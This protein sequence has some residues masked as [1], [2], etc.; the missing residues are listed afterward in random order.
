MNLPEKPDQMNGAFFQIPKAD[1][2]HIQRKW[3][4]NLMPIF[5]ILKHLIS[6]FPM[7]VMDLSRLSCISMEVLLQLETNGMFT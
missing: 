6:I 4:D 3:L 5:Q 2:S 1:V 7:K